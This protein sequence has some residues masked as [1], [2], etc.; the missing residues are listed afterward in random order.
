MSNI[1]TRYNPS[2]TEEKWYRVWEKGGYFQARLN[3]KKKPFSIVIPPPNVTGI[4]HMGHALNNTLQDIL[5]R[6]HRMKGEEAL[7][8][9]GTDHAGIATQNVV[10]RQIAKEGLRRKDLGREQFIERVW[11]WKEQYGSTIIKQLERLGCSCDWERARFTMDEE[12]S[13]SVGEVFVRLY[14]KG[15]IYQGD[16]IINWCPRCQTALSDEEAPHQEI[17]GFLYYIK[18]PLR[19]QSEKRKAQDYIVVATTRP[20]TMLGDTAVAVHPK[21]RRYKDLVGKTVI[22]PLI[23]RQIPIIADTS[24]ERNFGTGAVKVTPSHDPV[25]YQLGKKHNLEF[26]NIL[27]PEGSL[28]KNAGVYQGEERFQARKRIIEDLESQGLME[29]IEPHKLSVGH[30]YR[31]HTVIEPYLSRQWFVKMKPL[32]KRAIKVVKE[33]KI[34]FHPQ[35]WT[36]VYLNWM[37][38]IED[39]CISR[40]IWWGHR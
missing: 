16:Y 22:L 14:E 4:L 21:D 39:W 18:Y 20:E 13:L 1:P 8:M 9:P 38:N 12:Y 11:Q 25:D 6:Y 24:V 10:E 17:E 23:N 29:K 33:G 36:K 31:C 26:I 19:A 28:N 5:I 32:A 35:R 34:K 27:N 2:E 40:Q 37:E 15:L 3:P 30:C 7:W